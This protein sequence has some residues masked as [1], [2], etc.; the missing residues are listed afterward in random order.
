MHFKI[1][2]LKFKYDNQIVFDNK[3]FTIKR[4]QKLLIHGPSGCGKTTLINL[5]SGLLQSQFGKIIFE[6]EDLFEL[7]ENQLDKLRAKNFGFVFQRLYLINY[8]NV[9]QNIQLAKISSNSS[10]MNSLIEEL[11][12]LDKRKSKIRELSVGE[13][14][15]V[16]I[17]RAIVMSPKYLFCDEPNSGLDPKTAIVIDQ[18]I[19]EIT[20]EYNITTVINSHDM[21]SVIEIGENIIFLKDGKKLWQGTNKEILKTNSKHVQNFVYSSKLLKKLKN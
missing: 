18:L 9:E 4:G 7:S 1:E 11:G 10:D 19:Q 15:R 13:A 14:Q 2:N 20:K 5:M 16:A 3:N 6:N 21:N 8:L 12:L 17:A